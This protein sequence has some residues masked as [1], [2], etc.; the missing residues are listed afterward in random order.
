MPDFTTILII[1]CLQTVITGLLIWCG[2]KLVGEDGDIRALLLAALFAALV[3][4]VPHIGWLL[5]FGLL[6]F[7]LS[8]WTTADIFPSGVLIVVIARALGLFLVLFLFTL[9]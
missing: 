9:F 1:I 3:G 6:L 7:L 4:M 5:S 2:M 8:K